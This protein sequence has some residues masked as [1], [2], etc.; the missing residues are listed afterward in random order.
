MK[1]PAAPP[2]GHVIAY[3]YLWES[4]ADEKDDGAKTYP[5]ALI[6]SRVL[7]GGVTLAYALGI[8]HRPPSNDDRAIEVPLKLK[9]YLGLDDDPSWIYTDQLNIFAWPGPDLRPAER[10][11][12]RKDAEGSC[13]IAPLPVDWFELVKAHVI[14]SRVMGNLRARKRTA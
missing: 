10:L 3:E 6:L 9:R 2:V 14:E 7:E 5:C 8:S 1:I 11:S 13:V 4:Q 12:A